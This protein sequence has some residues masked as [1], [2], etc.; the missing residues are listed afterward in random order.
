MEFF[1]WTVEQTM[2]WQYAKVKLIASDEFPEL[3]N[4]DFLLDTWNVTFKKTE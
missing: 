4:K 3:V 1:D 2:E